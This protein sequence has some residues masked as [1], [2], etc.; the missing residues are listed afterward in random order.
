ML[1]LHSGQKVPF[2]FVLK[3]LLHY[4]LGEGGMAKAWSCAC[5]H[6]K[7]QYKSKY[8]LSASNAVPPSSPVDLHV[9]RLSLYGDRS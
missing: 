4:L 1:N 8:E 7:I 6:L 9:L 3:F 2:C 5:S